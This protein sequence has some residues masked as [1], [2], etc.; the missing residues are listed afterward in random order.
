MR[1][2]HEKQLKKPKEKEKEEE[3]DNV[4]SWLDGRLKAMPRGPA[5]LNRLERR[6]NGKRK[7]RPTTRWKRRRRR[8]RRK[9]R[10]QIRNK[11]IERE[12]NDCAATIIT[13]HENLIRHD[14]RKKMKIQSMER[15]IESKPCQEWKKQKNRQSHL[16]F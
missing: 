10:K 6:T 9:R 14:T 7:R 15:P 2:Y 13:G 12:R 1:S 4:A 8:R 3:E 16:I 11:K 5:P